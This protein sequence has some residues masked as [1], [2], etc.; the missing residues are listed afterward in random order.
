MPDNESKKRE[1]PISYRPPAALR[2]EFFARVAHSGMS[3]NA[4]LTQAVFE[5]A[6]GRS[7]RRPPIEKELLARLLSQAGH[8]RAALH[9]VALTGGDAPAN[10]MLIEAAL[11]DLTEIRAALVK[12][13]GRQQ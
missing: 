1:S 3:T 13:L 4:F 9:E 6:P 11:D 7:S 2:E 10:A 12:T 8:I 5:N